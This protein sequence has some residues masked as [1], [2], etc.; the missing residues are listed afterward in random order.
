ML[1]N[2]QLIGRLGRVPETKTFNNGGSVTQFSIATT[3]SWTDRESGERHEETEWHYIVARGR[4]GEIC[5]KYLSVGSRVYVEGKLR[6]RKWTNG[7]GVELY[8][9]EIIASEVKFLDSQNQNQNQNQNQG[10]NK[11]QAKNQGQ[12]QNQGRPTPTDKQPEAQIGGGYSGY[13]GLSSYSSN[14][15]DIDKDMPF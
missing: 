6:T 13:S 10:Q 11:G 1:N 4:L 3:D 5:Q 12:A 2:V 7:N 14:Q 15:E 8:R 9:T